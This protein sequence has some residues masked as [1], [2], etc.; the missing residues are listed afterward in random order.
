MSRR[1]V[2]P[3]RGG[4]RLRAR[5]L[6]L[7]LALGLALSATT[8]TA[9]AGASPQ[10][11]LLTKTAQATRLEAQISANAEQSDIL[12]EQYLQARNAVAD[13]NR[14][15]ASAEAGIASA[16]K[17][18]VGLRKR[19]GGRAALLYI[20]AGSGDPLG[21]DAASVQE[22]GARAK[23][24]EA[25][26]E[27]DDRMIDELK[28]LDEQL[29][30]QSHDLEKVKTEAQKRQNEADTARQALEKINATVQ[31]LLSS[32]KSDIRV[33]ANKIETQRIAAEAAAQRARFQAAAARAGR[34]GGCGGTEQ[35]WWR[36]RRCRHRLG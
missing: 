10:S 17:Q 9:P 23:Y 30:I 27:T 6:T 4:T 20:G 11:D 35:R 2:C 24:G 12:N 8:M 33:L 1:S 16:R 5:H 29:G 18:Q 7:G 31:Q 21:F 25:A 3:H 15:I 14:Q 22:L 34:G 19:L 26:A 36:R 28:V 32:T 13:M